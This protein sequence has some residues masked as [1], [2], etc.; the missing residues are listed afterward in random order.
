M[1]GVKA[2]LYIQVIFF[3]QLNAIFVVL[4]YRTCNFNIAHA[5]LSPQYARGVKLLKWNLMQLQQHKLYGLHD[6]NGL[7]K[8][9]LTSQPKSKCLIIHSL[10]IKFINQHNQTLLKNW[11]KETFQ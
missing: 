5:I 4:Q 2:C 7:Y 11:I 8:G 1:F 9:T 3:M 6:K 10:I